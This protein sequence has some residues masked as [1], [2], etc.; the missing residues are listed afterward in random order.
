MF[1]IQAPSKPFFTSRCIYII[2]VSIYL[3]L[4][5]NFWDDFWDDVCDDFW[6]DFWNDL[7]VIFWD[8]FW[9]KFKEQF[10]G[11]FFKKF[12]FSSMC[13]PKFVK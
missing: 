6:D 12:V 8:D 13:R 5:N 7:R 3:D 1:L 11:Q 9:D 4:V 10:H 2:P